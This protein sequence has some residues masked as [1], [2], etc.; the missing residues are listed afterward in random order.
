[1]PLERHP[2]RVPYAAQCMGPDS[3]LT[4]A[5]DEWSRR[6]LRSVTITLGAPQI[7]HERFIDLHN[8]KNEAVPSV[9]STF[10]V[11]EN[12]E[13]C[14]D[15][16]VDQQLIGRIGNEPPSHDAV[17]VPTDNLNNVL[18]LIDES[19][20]RLIQAGYPGCVGC[21]GEDA[22]EPWDEFASR[23]RLSQ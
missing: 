22:L 10:D 14:L 11:I 2:S 12:N 7:H 4:R 5:I 8:M 9:Y 20:Q 16:L 15:L 19:I 6:F 13:G 17:H 23:V 18:D 1:M 21:G 3:A